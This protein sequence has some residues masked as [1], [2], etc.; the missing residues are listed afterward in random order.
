MQKSPAV[1]VYRGTL[2]LS[3]I[4][5]T[6][7][8]CSSQLT[9]EKT[10]FKHLFNHKINRAVPELLEICFHIKI[11]VEPIVLFRG[12]EYYPKNRCRTRVIF[13]TS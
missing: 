5:H 7:K 12:I 3:P 11:G 4:A 10:V 13:T 6:P 1:P 9:L 2:L 8:P